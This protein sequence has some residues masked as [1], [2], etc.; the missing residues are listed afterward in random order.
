MVVPERQASDCKGGFSEVTSSIAGVLDAI[1]WPL[2]VL[3]IV[4]TFRKGLTR[5]ISRLKKGKFGGSEWEFESLLEEAERDA[6]A[7][8]PEAGLELDPAV[9]GLLETQP[10]GAVI[11]AWLEIE[12]LIDELSY[13]KSLPATRPQ[14]KSPI[15]AI[16]ELERAQILPPDYIALLNDLR[17]LRNEAA[18]SR[19]FDPSPESVIRYLQLSSRVIKALRKAKDQPYGG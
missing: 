8:S 4:R 15:N 10:R 6:P 2:V 7:P 18:H 1:A 12:R 9:V 16:R 17:V 13:T 19:D 5:L 3:I 14:R 11:T